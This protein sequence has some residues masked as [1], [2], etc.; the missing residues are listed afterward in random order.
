MEQL[1]RLCGEVG[2]RFAQLHERLSLE[3]STAAFSPAG[4]LEE[5]TTAVAFQPHTQVK[6]NGGNKPYIKAYYIIISL[7]IVTKN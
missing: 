6:K 1:R 4:R 3:A 7:Y 5:F 2:R